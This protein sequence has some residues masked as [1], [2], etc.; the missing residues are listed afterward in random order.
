MAR[1]GSVLLLA[2]SVVTLGQS[3]ASSAAAGSGG[4]RSETKTGFAA[5]AGVAI[6]PDDVWLVG[7]TVTTT[8]QT[9]ARHWNGSAWVNVPTPNPSAVYDTLVGVSASSSNDVWAVGTYGSGGWDR[10]PLAEHWDGSSWTVVPVP[11]LP[12]TQ[13]GTESLSAVSVIN[14]H[15]VWALGETVDPLLA[16]LLHWDGSTWSTE[17]MRDGQYFGLSAASDHDVWTTTEGHPSKWDGS[18]WTD[19]FLDAYVITAA[20]VAPDDVWFA[21]NVGWSHSMRDSFGHFN[22]T[23]WTTSAPDAP[24]HANEIRS[25]SA[26]S[27]DDVWASGQA[28]KDKFQ[29]GQVFH[30]DGTSSSWSPVL[31]R[32]HLG[33]N[34]SGV[35][36]VGAHEAWA[37]G[38]PNGYDSS[39]NVIHWDGGRW[40]AYTVP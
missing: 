40:K 12:W 39:V 30:W 31:R 20:A 38:D 28:T 6:A 34:V 26:V 7:G 11:R 4:Q 2:T 36:G 16:F 8:V 23:G 17:G 1:V 32:T 5:E 37:W 27:S 21:G 22:G 33:G 9:A 29:I 14:A 3:A 18:R 15:D 35:V 10:E 24:G 19:K 13:P 25:L